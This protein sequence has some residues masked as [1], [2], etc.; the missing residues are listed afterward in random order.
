MLK[1]LKISKGSQDKP[2]ILLKNLSN[3]IA[4]DLTKYVRTPIRLYQG[5]TN[6]AQLCYTRQNYQGK[7]DI[8]FRFIIEYNIL[9]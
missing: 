4:W 2:L 3:C 5:P 9:A 1:V 8:V 7:K 6:A